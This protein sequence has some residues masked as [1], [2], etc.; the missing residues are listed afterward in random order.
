[1]APDKA[2]ADSHCITTPLFGQKPPEIDGLLLTALTGIANDTAAPAG[3][4]IV[5]RQI[6]ATGNGT[7]R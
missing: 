5:D 6:S 1:V 3:V 7:S 4:R 2:P